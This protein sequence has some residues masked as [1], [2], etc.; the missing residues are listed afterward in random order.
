MAKPASFGRGGD[1]V[2]DPAYRSA[3]ELPPDSFALNHVLPS[4]AIMADIHSVLQPNAPAIEAQLYKVGGCA[5]CCSVFECLS[6]TDGAE[7][8]FHGDLTMLLP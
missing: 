2:L 3:L 6:C 8:I 7:Y 1:A 5:M 4:A